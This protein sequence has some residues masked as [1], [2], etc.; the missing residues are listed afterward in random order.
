[1]SSGLRNAPATFQQL[2]HLV[3]TEVEICEVY[4]GDAVAYTA[5]Y[6]VP[7]PENPEEN[8]LEVKGGQPHPEFDKV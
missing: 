8:I 2:M 7:A 3:L 6:L 4:L 5:T 1:M